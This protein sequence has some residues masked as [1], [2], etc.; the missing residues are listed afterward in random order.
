[1]NDGILARSA[2]TRTDKHAWIA[3][4]RAVEKDDVIHIFYK[5]QTAP[6]VRFLGSF[7]V[8]DPDGARFDPTCDLAVVSEPLAARLREAYGTPK[9]EPMTGWRIKPVS[10]R[11]TPT[12]EEPDVDKFLRETPTLVRYPEDRIVS[13]V[14]A[15]LPLLPD[16]LRLPY[17]PLLVTIETWSYGVTV[18]RLPAAILIGEGRDDRSALEALAENIAE[19]VEVHLPHAQ[20]GRLGGTLAKQWASLSAMVDISAVH[21]VPEKSREVA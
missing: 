2:R 16:P 1:V 5:Q 21:V 17:G 10:D 13:T 6:H 11:R 12:P 20:A 15:Q 7:C 9:G 4:V 18:A 14:T 3:N 8:Q 19:F